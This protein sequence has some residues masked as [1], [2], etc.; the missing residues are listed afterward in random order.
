MR[1]KASEWIVD[2]AALPH[3]VQA[4]TRITAVDG[5][6]VSVAPSA[7]GQQVSGQSAS[8]PSASGPA[9]VRLRGTLLPGLVDLQVNGAGGRSV[10]EASKEAL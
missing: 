3:V 1:V 6:I 4:E 8:G 2:R 10:D 7:G 5:R 9:A